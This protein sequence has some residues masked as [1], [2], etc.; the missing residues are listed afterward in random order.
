MCTAGKRS[1]ILVH[2]LFIY[3]YLLFNTATVRLALHTR[4]SFFLRSPI[5][6]FFVLFL[7]LFFSFV[8]V[9]DMLTFHFITD[10]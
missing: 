4:V 8:C 10:T 2:S 1:I 6:P 3:F 7:F 5:R 9:F